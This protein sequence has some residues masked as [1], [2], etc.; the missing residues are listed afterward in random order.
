MMTTSMPATPASTPREA[1]R[2]TLE[3]GMQGYAFDAERWGRGV[4]QGLGD[5]SAR[6]ASLVLPMAPANPVPAGDDETAFVRALV[7]DPVFQLR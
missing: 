7:S 3:S 2:R 4:E 5:R 1:L 6:V